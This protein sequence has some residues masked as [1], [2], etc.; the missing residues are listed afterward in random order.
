MPRDGSVPM[1]E[2]ALDGEKRR[3]AVDLAQGRRIVRLADADE[4]GAETMGAGKLL[5]RFGHGW[6]RGSRGWSRRARQFGQHFKRRFGRA[7]MI[8]EVAKGRGADIVAA[9]QPQPGNPLSFRQRNPVPSCADVDMHPI[10]SAPILLSV[11]AQQPLNIRPV[12]DPGDEGHD[13]EEQADFSYPEYQQYN[14]NDKCCNQCREGGVTGELAIA[15]QTAAKTRT[16]I[17]ASAEQH[18]DIGGD[19]L[20]A[21]EAEPDREEMAEEGGKAGGD[22]GFDP[23]ARGNCRSGSCPSGHR[24]AASR[25]RASC[26][27]CAAHWSRRYCRSRSCGRHQA[28]PC[29]SGSGRRGW[30]R[31]DSR[32]SR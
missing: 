4:A 26:C 9:D 29:A 12:L 6:R 31:A 21:L 23:P 27:R 2:I 11:P 17:G 20:A 22:A 10:P 8:D 32:R 1:A 30:S 24:A 3:R 28:R 19:A 13:R 25:R 16:M 18:A 14:R 15:S 7:E 5:F